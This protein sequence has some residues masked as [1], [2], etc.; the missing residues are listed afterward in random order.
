MPRLR[1]LNGLGYHPVT[2]AG[3]L[4]S[5]S[6]RVNAVFGDAELDRQ[7]RLGDR[8]RRCFNR[9]VQALNLL[10]QLIAKAAGEFQSIFCSCVMGSL[11]PNRVMQP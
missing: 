5:I 6:Q 1:A 2:R 10:L 4:P 11:S 7:P 3:Y 9:K 8:L